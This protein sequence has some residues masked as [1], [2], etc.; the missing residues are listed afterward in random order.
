MDTI[1]RAYRIS[2]L[3]CR[4]LGQQASGF[5]RAWGLGF[6]DLGS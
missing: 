3:G 5:C 2:G 6:G 4:V 1:G